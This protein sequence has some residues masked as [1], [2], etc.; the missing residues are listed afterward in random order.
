MTQFKTMTCYL[1]THERFN[2]LI[3]EHFGKKAFD[4]VSAYELEN[5]TC[6]LGGVS[7]LDCDDLAIEKAI[8]EFC[9]SEAPEALDWTLDWSTML[10]VLARRGIVPEGD[11]LLQ[12]N[13]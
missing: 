1:I 7:A 11:Y 4:C 6:Y 13:Y 10:A 12:V 9:A 5:G 2:N 3:Q 8:N